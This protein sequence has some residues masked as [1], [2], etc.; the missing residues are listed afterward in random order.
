MSRDT[1]HRLWSRFWRVFI[2]YY[3]GSSYNDIMKTYFKCSDEMK[4]QRRIGYKAI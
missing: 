2:D 3:N 4:S 1:N